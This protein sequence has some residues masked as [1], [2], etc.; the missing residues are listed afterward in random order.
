M[1]NVRS[2]LLECNCYRSGPSYERRKAVE[3]H[4]MRHVGAACRLESAVMREIDMGDSTVQATFE[5]VYA[6]GDCREI[7]PRIDRALL[8][9]G[10]V[11]LRAL[12][13]GVDPQAAEAVVA[14]AAAT[15]GTGAPARGGG[16]GARSVGRRG[17][18]AVLAGTLVGAAVGAAAGAIVENRIPHH[19]AVKRLGRWHVKRLSRG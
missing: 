8:D 1:K 5:L 11:A 13:S 10:I 14:G 19:V 4:V 6:G 9:V 16:A 2:I 3:E 18:F 17:A 15:D 7:I 12:V